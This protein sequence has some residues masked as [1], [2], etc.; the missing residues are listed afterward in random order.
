MRVKPFYSNGANKKRSI[1]KTT[2]DAEIIQI[3]LKIVF[4]FGIFMR[5]V[6]TRL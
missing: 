5:K 3:I 6:F 1:L 2:I 4:D